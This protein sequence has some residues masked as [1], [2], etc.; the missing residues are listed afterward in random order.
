M[1]SRREHLMKRSHF[2]RLLLAPSLTLTAAGLSLAQDAPVQIAVHWDKI[3]QESRT[4]PTLQVVV[5]PPLRRGTPV[6]DNAFQALHD[7]GADFVRYVPWLPYPRL[8]VA[9]LEH[10][11]DGKTS[12]DFSIIDLLSI[13]FLLATK[14]QLFVHIV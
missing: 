3:V 8:G 11:K 14:L 4:T 2:F 1:R 13:D 6:H 10:P 7:L 12:W 5:N 9:E